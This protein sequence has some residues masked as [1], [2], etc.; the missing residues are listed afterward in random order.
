MNIYQ[1]FVNVFALLVSIV[2]AKSVSLSNHSRKLSRC[3]G[4]FGNGSKTPIPASFRADLQ[5]ILAARIISS[6]SW[7]MHVASASSEWA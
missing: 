7:L 3:L 1:R 6:L 2:C 4:I 5:V